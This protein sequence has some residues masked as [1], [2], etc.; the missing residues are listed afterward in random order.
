MK[1]KTDEQKLFLYFHNVMKTMQKKLS[2]KSGK[3]HYRKN[4]TQNNESKK[5]C[6]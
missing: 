3:K 4:S 2:I 1:I 6:A 5:W